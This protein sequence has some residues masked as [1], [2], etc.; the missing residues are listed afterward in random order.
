MV[1]KEDA[2]NALIIIDLMVIDTLADMEASEEE[3]GRDI[4]NRWHAEAG[5]RWQ[6]AYTYG[7]VSEETK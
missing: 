4:I 3:G 6:L 2:Q 1:S 7:L 5:L